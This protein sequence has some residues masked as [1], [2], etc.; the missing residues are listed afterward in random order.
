MYYCYKMYIF[1]SLSELSTVYKAKI[2]DISLSIVTGHYD[3]VQ[4][5]TD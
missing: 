4:K 5:K 1:F 2:E 3:T